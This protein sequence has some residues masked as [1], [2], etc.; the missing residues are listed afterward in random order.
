MNCNGAHV[1][2]DVFRIGRLS[3]LQPRISMAELSSGL[4]GTDDPLVLNHVTSLIRLWSQSRIDLPDDFC[5]QVRVLEC[6]R[7]PVALLGAATQYV[8]RSLRPVVEPFSD[9]PFNGAPWPTADLFELTAFNPLQFPHVESATEEPLGGQEEVFTCTGCEGAGAV[10]CDG[11]RSAGRV[12]CATCRGAKE[13]LCTKCNGSGTF[14]RGQSLVDCRSC[15]GRGSQAC[16]LCDDLG[17]IAC[18]GCEGTGQVECVTCRGHQRL[19]RRWVLQTALST[20]TRHIGLLAEPWPIVAE[21]LLNEA[22]VIGSRE[23]VHGARAAGD[24]LSEVPDHLTPAAETLLAAATGEAQSLDQST[25]RIS[26]VRL[27][28]YGT[29]AF[30]VQFEYKDTTGTVYIGGQ[31]NRVFPARIPA[32]APVSLKLYNGGDEAGRERSKRLDRWSFATLL[33]GYAGLCGAAVAWY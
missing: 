5:D 13:V 33:A 7:L 27:T 15:G 22:D 23:W 18:A 30:R 19:K 4:M 21:S 12:T 11:C 32:T 20:R 2:P 9:A 10:G 28:V 8:Q 26:G 17:Q 24:R 31:G 16:A 14:V 6:D 29:Y 3:S 1:E 25:T